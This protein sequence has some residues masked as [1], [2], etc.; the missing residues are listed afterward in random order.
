MIQFIGHDGGRDSHKVDSS[1][2]KQL[3][4]KSIVG[5]AR[6]RNLVEDRDYLVEID[7]RQWFVGDLARESF[8][9][10]QMATESKIHED[11]KIL[12]LTSLALAAEPASELVVTTGLPINQH[13]PETKQKLTEL[14]TGEHS[15]RINNGSPKLIKITNIGIVP[16]GAGAYFSEL[17]DDNGIIKNEWLSKQLKRVID[18]GSRT[19][20]ICT[21]DENNRYLDRDSDTL[22]YGCLELDN[23]A[24]K[25]PSK[26]DL[27]EFARKLAG[28]IN[29][30]L[31]SYRPAKDV[32][33]LSGGGS[34]VLGDYL[35]TYFPISI[36]VNNPVFA[37]AI[38]YRRM[39]MMR[40]RKTSR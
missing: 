16:E 18:I 11:T 25:N 31:Q 40:W 27:E 3:S 37:N 7:S 1:T 12:F 14:L 2:G 35:K 33:L 38:G 23:A 28:D 15:V 32:V 26:E 19:V 4:V 5:K 6:S 34:L 29:K 36:I 24:G 17:L 22:H 30:R 20:N 9:I 10:R 13:T 39:G 21:I 8:F